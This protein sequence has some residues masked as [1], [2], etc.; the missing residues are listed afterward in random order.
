MNNTITKVSIIGSVGIP[1]KY[2]GFETLVEYLTK[3]LN[4]DIDFTVFCSSK[5]YECQEKIH[6][7]AS[8]KYVPLKANGIQSIPYDIWSLL[9]VKR[10]NKVVLILGV[11]CGFFLPIYKIF[12]NKKIVLNVDG[13]EWKREKWGK[14]AKWYLKNSERIA[15][16]YSDIIVADNKIIQEHVLESYGK[17]AELIE[18]GGDHVMPKLMSIETSANYSFTKTNYA[19][20]VCRIEPE[21]NIHMILESFSSQTK[22]NIVIV[23]NWKNSPYGLELIKKYDSFKH[24]HLLD[25]IYNQSILDELRSN[26]F[27]YVHGHSAG[28]TNPSLVEAMFLNIPI[29]T[30]DVN[31][32]RETTENKALGYFKNASDLNSIIENLSKKTIEKSILN[33]THIAIN[34]YNWALISQKYQSI[35]N[36]K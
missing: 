31:Y 14:L 18:Y 2:G 3:N 10:D 4:K 27:M 28:G 29:L 24:I 13:L 1:A 21:N 22:Y 23:G 20:K 25:P 35:F 5:E 15:V 12:T 17:N 32:N 7:G 9:K 30:F 26:C 19:F 36:L 6:N 34:R 11:A 8:L 33:L 16:R